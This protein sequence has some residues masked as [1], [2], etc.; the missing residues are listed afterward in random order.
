MN[1][2]DCACCAG[3][4]LDE[5][6]A[7][8][9]DIIERH[10]WAIQYVSGPQPWA[11]TVGLSLSF[12]HPELVVTGLDYRASGDLLNELGEQ[13][14][15][16][17]RLRPGPTWAGDRSVDLVGVHPMHWSTDLFAMWWAVS[18][19]L[20]IALE[21]EP[22]ALQVLVATDT[23]R[24]RLDQPPSRTARRAATRYR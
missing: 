18:D 1:T 4:T 5:V 15:G 23:A 9:L 21:S 10:G 14:R 22:V 7:D 8:N 17:D 12:A 16:G 20:E 3:M 6:I 2:H 19:Q 11:Y 13:A 24:H